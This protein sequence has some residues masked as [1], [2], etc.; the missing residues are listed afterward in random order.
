MKESKINRRMHNVQEQLNLKNR[1][2]I[3]YYFN[4]KY[5]KS[6]LTRKLKNVFIHKSEIKIILKYHIN[7]LFLSIYSYQLL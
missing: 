1:I 7:I 5:N 6:K 4:K 2:N 3:V